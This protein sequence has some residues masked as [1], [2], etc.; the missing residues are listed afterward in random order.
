M[1]VLEQANLLLS[2][3]SVA[4]SAARWETIPDAPKLGAAFKGKAGP[5][6][7]TVLGFPIEDQGFPPGT[8][9]YEAAASNMETLWVV[10]LPQD[11]AKKCFDAANAACDKG[12]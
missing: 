5:W 8:L 11:M 3:I 7:I 4:L 6:L 12:D 9:G 2:Q 1:D 10:H